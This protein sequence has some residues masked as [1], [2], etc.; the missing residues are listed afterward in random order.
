MDANAHGGY[1]L[2][3]KKS[4]AIDDLVLESQNVIRLSPLALG[5]MLEFVAQ[6]R[7]RAVRKSAHALVNRAAIEQRKTFGSEVG[8]SSICSEREMKLTR[9]P[10]Q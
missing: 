3:D 4:E 10:A 9:T 1:F 7:Q 8:I 5:Q 2:F 6:R